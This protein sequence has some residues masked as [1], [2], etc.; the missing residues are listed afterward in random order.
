MTDGRVACTACGAK[1]PED[2]ANEGEFLPCPSCLRLERVFAF[3]ALHRPMAATAALP[4][5]V[6]G[7]ASCFYHGHKRAVVACDSCGRF[8]CALCDVE[9]G[10]SHR[11]PSCLQAGKRKGSADSLQTR[12]TL[13]DGLALMLAVVPLLVW[14]FTIFTAPA[15]I[16]VAIKYWRRPLSVVPRTRVRLVVALL[17]AVAQLVGWMIL[18]YYVIAR[19]RGGGP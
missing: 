4:A 10:A 3:P 17:L 13:W 19:I 18:A 16:F 15:A 14:P 11:C 5:M 2:F 1:L 12:G 9:L 7:E 6:D 8:L